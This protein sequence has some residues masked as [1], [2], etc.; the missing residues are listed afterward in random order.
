MLLYQTLVLQQSKDDAYEE[1]RHYD[2]DP[3]RNAALLPYLGGILPEVVDAL[4]AY[5]IAPPTFPKINELA[6]Q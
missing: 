1:M 2:F 3:E 5:G 6:T 4:G